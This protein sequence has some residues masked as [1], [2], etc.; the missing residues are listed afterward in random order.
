MS[1]VKM[2]EKW[3]QSAATQEYLVYFSVI[4]L[5]SVLL[6]SPVAFPLDIT[7]STIDFVQAIRSIPDGGI[8]LWDESNF[9]TGYYTQNQIALYRLFFDQA[10]QRGVKIIFIS[11]CVDGPMAGAM[12]NKQLEIQDTTGLTYGVDYVNLGWLPGFEIVL[13]AIA[14]DIQTVT[15]ADAYGTSISEIPLMQG[16]K[17]EDIDLFAFNCGVSCDPWMRQWVPLHKPLLMTGGYSLIAQAQGYIQAGSITA[18]LN[19]SRGYVE[20]ERITGYMTMQT[21][22]FEA[23]NIM[24]P[25]SVL[26]VIL[27]NV[28]YMLRKRRKREA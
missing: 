12:I 2:A 17:T 18:Y 27:T 13:S 14:K 6:L 15:S 23:T 16:L 9:V 28:W 3:Y 21:A 1:E 19:G 11:S 10:K 22:L 4:L 24:G 20:M 26:L 8:M 7:Q 25:F 5:S